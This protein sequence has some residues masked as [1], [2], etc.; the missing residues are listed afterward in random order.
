MANIF[1]LSI[2]GAHWR[3]S[4]NTTEPPVCGGDAALCH[5]TL[6]TYY[7]YYY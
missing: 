6:T 2:C 5:V 4:V 3:H 7:Y 1:W